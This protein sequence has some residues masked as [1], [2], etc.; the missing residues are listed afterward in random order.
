MLN[1]RNSQLLTPLMQ[2]VVQ[3]QIE[4]FIYILKKFNSIYMHSDFDFIDLNGNNIL[5]LIVF[6]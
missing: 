1:L 5:H 2:C 3:G 6:Q 4:M